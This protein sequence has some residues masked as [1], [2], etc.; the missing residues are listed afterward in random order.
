MNQQLFKTR[1]IHACA[2]RVGT[3]GP[4]GAVETGEGAALSLFAHSLTAAAAAATAA[5][6]AFV[7]GSG[8]TTCS[9][10]ALGREQGCQS[11][12]VLFHIGEVILKECNVP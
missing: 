2:P 1:P 11:V 12:S 10:N 6:E 8:G 7:L 9:V 4:C 3:P 5:A